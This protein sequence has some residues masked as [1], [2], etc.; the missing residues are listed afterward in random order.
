MLNQLVGACD[1]VQGNNFANIECGASGI[2]LAISK[3]LTL[4]G[5]NVVPSGRR[6]RD[7]KLPLPQSKLWEVN[8]WRRRVTSRI[9]I[10]SSVS[11]MQSAANLE[12]YRKDNQ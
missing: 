3:A 11:Y 7:W 8:P 9:K 5:A 6:S 4:A 10:A 1:L 12:A 2:G